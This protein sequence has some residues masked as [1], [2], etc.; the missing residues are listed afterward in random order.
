MF[1]YN[2]WIIDSNDKLKWYTQGDSLDFVENRAKLF[3]DGTSKSK[4]RKVLITFCPKH[5]AQNA[6]EMPAWD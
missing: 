4:Y 2:V 3:K 6:F 5:L 1:V